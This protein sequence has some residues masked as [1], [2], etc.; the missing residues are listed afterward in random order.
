MGRRVLRSPCAD[1]GPREVGEPRQAVSFGRTSRPNAS[2]HAV[3]LR[4]TLCR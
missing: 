1:A 2:I 4:P 3:W